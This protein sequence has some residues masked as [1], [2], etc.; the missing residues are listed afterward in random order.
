M[1][2]E[3]IGERWYNVEHDYEESIVRLIEIGLSSLQKERILLACRYCDEN[4]NSKEASNRDYQLRDS[5]FG[6][7]SIFEIETDQKARR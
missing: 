4:R 6:S 3:E 1:S 2:K 5:G 7:E